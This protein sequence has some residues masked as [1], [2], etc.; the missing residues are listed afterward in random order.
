VEEHLTGSVWT[1]GKKVLSWL[2]TFNCLLTI[3]LAVGLLTGF[4]TAHWKIYQP[5]LWSPNLL[6]A[7]VLTSAMN[8]FPTASFGHVK[9]IRLKFHHF[10]Y[11][12]AIFAT[13]AAFI[14]FMSFSI[15]SLFALNIPSVNFNVV[16]VFALVGLTLIIDDFAD[17]SN[18]TRRGLCLVKSKAYQKRDIIYAVQCLLCCMTIL[19]FLC[20]T[21]WLTQTPGGRNLKNLA[22]E[23]SLLVTS[24]T[25]FESI[26][27]KVWLKITPQPAETD[28]EKAL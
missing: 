13:S 24:L 17:I 27:K 3:M 23:G 14:T 9:V 25:T 28:D 5:Y 15:L 26:R 2:L 4:Y 21:I 8:F 19:V 7:T 11:G 16:R 18:R 12:L 22:M 10:I 6:W 1:Y 20:L